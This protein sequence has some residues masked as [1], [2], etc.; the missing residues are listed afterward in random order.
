MPA[1]DFPQFLKR[2]GIQLLGV[3]NTDVAPGEV[4]DKARK[5]FMPQGHL[6]EILSSQPSAFWDTELNRANMIYGTVERTL[7]LDGSASLTEM[8][9]QI[10]GGLKSAK[11]VTF[12]ITGVNARTFVNGPGHASMFSLVPL[13]NA[14]KGTDRSK[15]KM[16]NGK[17][18]VTETYYATQAAV[19][20]QTSGGVNLKAQVEEAGGVRAGGGGQVEWTSNKAFTMTQNDGV[21]FGF[22][23]WKV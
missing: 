3:A 7:S 2:F 15:W 11:S 14:L 8:G 6:Q 20:F 4:V 10:S 5:G 19:S 13:I 22:R 9:V 12:S 18:I 23:G 16:V 1:L 17:W 21:P